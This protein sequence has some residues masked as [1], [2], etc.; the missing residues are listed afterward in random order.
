LGFFQSNKDGKSSKKN[1]SEYFMVDEHKSSYLT[2]SS[3]AD[4][5]A[6]DKISEDDNR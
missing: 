4:I 6:N 5:E 1:Y 2:Y 3:V